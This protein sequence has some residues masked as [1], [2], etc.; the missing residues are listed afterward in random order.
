[1]MARTVVNLDERLLKRAMKLSGVKKKVQLVNWGLQVLVEHL[2]QEQ[3]LKLRGKVHWEGDLD[4]WR[5]RVR[6]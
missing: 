5:G 4:L 6:R 1:M 3:V 2:L